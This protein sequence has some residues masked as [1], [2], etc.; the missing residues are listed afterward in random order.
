V[1]ATEVVVATRVLAGDAGEDFADPR[2]AAAFAAAYLAVA[3]GLVDLGEPAGDVI[4]VVEEEMRDHAQ[5]VHAL[6]AVELPRLDLSEQLL[7]QHG[8]ADAVRAIDERPRHPLLGGRERLLDV[9]PVAAA[10][11][12]RDCSR[13]RPRRPRGWRRCS[14]GPCP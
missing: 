3:L 5:Q 10:R 7:P 2:D 9:R 13:A 1:L 14:R 12:G 6:G 4:D 11:A 8:V